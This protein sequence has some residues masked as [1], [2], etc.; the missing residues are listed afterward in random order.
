MTERIKKKPVISPLL[1]WRLKKGLSQEKMC[2][3]L[4]KYA[5]RPLSQT[6]YGYWER[7]TTPRK[8]WLKV[9]L[10]FTGIEAAAFL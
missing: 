5:G 3:E 4:E 10:E 9:L 8:F 1:K 2:S 7:G 6:T